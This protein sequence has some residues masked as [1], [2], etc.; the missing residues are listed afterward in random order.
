MLHCDCTV[1]T[2][3]GKQGKNIVFAVQILW[4]M[5]KESL[6]TLEL[7][8]AI[9]LHLCGSFQQTKPFFSLLLNKLNM[10]QYFGTKKSIKEH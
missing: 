1:H 6:F 9:V 3:K 7:A 5:H 2:V 10:H 8:I 4:E